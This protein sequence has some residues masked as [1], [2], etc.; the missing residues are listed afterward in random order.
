MIN[1]LLATQRKKQCLGGCIALYSHHSAEMSFIVS[2]WWKTGSLF[3]VI[4][5]LVIT[6]LTF[7]NEILTSC[8][9]ISQR[10]A[11]H[12]WH[13]K[14]NYFSLLLIPKISL[15]S[16]LFPLT[17]RVKESSP[18]RFNYT[19][20]HLQVLCLWSTFTK[21]S[22]FTTSLGET[23]RQCIFPIFLL[24]CWDSSAVNG[25][26]LADHINS[27]VNSQSWHVTPIISH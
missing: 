20:K 26:S 9:E 6:D 18:C 13:M 2:L 7:K 4:L 10:D 19:K 12:L 17:W 27:F 11:W 5:P 24:F 21:C 1:P 25:I 22:G 23:M 15:Y 8:H 3:R 14:N 16:N